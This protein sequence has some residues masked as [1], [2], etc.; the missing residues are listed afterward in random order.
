MI[1]SSKQT[2]IPESDDDFVSAAYVRFTFGEVSDM[3][4]HRQIQRDLIS[5]PD[6]II[7][8]KRFWRR[9]TIA[10]DKARL[11]RMA[12]DQPNPAAHLRRRQVTSK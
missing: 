1:R 12:T 3:W 8:G 2:A 10:D 4:L 6:A 5:K 9:K 7:N 11:I